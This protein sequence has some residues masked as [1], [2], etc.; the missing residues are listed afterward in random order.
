MSSEV[1]LPGRAMARTGLRMMPT[2]PWLPLKSRNGGFSPVRFQGRYIRR[3]FLS[4]TSSSH[5]AVCLR[6]SCIS[7]PGS[8]YPRAE[9]RDEVR[10]C[11]TVQT[12]TAALPQGPSLRSGLCC[13]GPSSL[14]WSHAPH[15]QAQPDFAA[16]RLIRAVLAVR[17]RA[18]PSRLE[19]VLPNPRPSNCRSRSRAFATTTASI[20]LGTSM[21]AISGFHS[22]RT[23]NRRRLRSQRYGCFCEWRDL[24]Q[25]ARFP[26]S[27]LTPPKAL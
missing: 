9:S 12:A 20:L 24:A 6:P 23:R 1:H 11:T 2:F 8:S 17:H 25:I 22:T 16:R 10:G 21:P 27:P 5:R 19:I 18:T 4:I 3:A 7:L 13:P 26:C 15:S 14:N